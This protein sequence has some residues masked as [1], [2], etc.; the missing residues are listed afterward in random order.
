MITSPLNKHSL[1][2]SGY[3]VIVK[4][5]GIIYN[6]IQFNTIQYNSIQEK[7]ENIF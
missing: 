5:L 4:K 6:S 2:S 1:H 7:I 3:D